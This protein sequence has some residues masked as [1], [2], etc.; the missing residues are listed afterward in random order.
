MNGALVRSHEVRSVVNLYNT[1]PHKYNTGDD[2]LLTMK[3]ARKLI[4]RHTHL[5]EEKKSIFLFQ[6]QTQSMIPTTKHLNLKQVRIR[7]YVPLIISSDL[8][9]TPRNK[10]KKCDAVSF[11][12]DKLQDELA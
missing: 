10:K 3:R 4:W 9:F 5:T 8:A 12:S 1:R 6:S 11:S 2:A 7:L